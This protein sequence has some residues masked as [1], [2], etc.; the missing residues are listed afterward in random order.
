M[1]NAKPFYLLPL[2]IRTSQ[3][4]SVSP[5]VGNHRFNFAVPIFSYKVNP[6]RESQTELPTVSVPESLSLEGAAIDVIC[7]LYLRCP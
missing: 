3:Y 6:Q 5:T 4:V 2:L 7:E 1:I